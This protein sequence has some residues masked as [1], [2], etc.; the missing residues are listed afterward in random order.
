MEENCI[1]YSYFKSSPRV[2]Y[3]NRKERIRKE[4]ETILLKIPTNQGLYTK[5]Y[6]HSCTH[7]KLCI[8][9]VKDVQLCIHL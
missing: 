6:T 9:T 1:S 3:N 5:I 2:L 8:T 4:L 7:T